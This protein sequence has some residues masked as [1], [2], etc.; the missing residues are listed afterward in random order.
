MAKLSHSQTPHCL[1]FCR[2]RLILSS[3]RP[4]HGEKRE[5]IAATHDEK[6]KEWENWREKWRARDRSVGERKVR[7]KNERK[8]ANKCY[9][10]AKKAASWYFTLNE[11]PITQWHP[12]QCALVCVVH[13]VYI[14]ILF[15]CDSAYIYTYQWP[16]FVVYGYYQ[17][18]IMRYTLCSWP[19]YNHSNLLLFIC[20][21]VC[22]YIKPHMREHAP[23][24][25]HVHVY[26]PYI[27]WIF[28]KRKK[29]TL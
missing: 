22:V 16:I 19:Y 17:I 8:K 15:L 12:F 18:Q 10:S 2:K 27:Q 14:S 23:F 28:E 3:H 13:L 25:M 9:E 6:E 24:E 21:C 26:S 1:K 20:N 7:M 11:M 5:K 4:M 29:N